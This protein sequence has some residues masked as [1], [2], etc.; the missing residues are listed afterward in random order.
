[1]ARILIKTAGLENQFLDLKLGTNR[2]GRSQDCDLPIPHPT[3]SGLHCEIVL[4]DEGVTIRDMEST[5]GT[6]VDGMRVREAALSSGQTLRLGDVELLVETTEVTVSIPKFIDPDL[7]AP[8]V[9]L[10]DGSLICPRHPHAQVTHRCTHCKEVMCEECVHRMR[11][12]GSKRVLL[13]CPICSHPIELISGAS[14]RTKKKSFF[15]RVGETVKLKMTRT[16]P[17]GDH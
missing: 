5:N 8:P 1:M 10:E 7:P 13:L 16:I 2:I 15:A 4:G 9:V 14:K 17:H 6:F 11:R 3:V 12:K